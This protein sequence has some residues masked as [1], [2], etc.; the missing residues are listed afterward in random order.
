[1]THPCLFPTPVVHIFIPTRFLRIAAFAGILIVC[2]AVG[3]VGQTPVVSGPLIFLP[4]V[5]YSEGLNY[6]ILIPAA[7]ADVNGDGKLDIALISTST[8]VTVALGNGDGSFQGPQSYSPG[9]YPSGL[10][11]ADVNGDGK[12]DLVVTGC[13]PGGDP[14][15]PDAV[16]VML[17]NGDGSFKSGP[18][19][20]TG[21]LASVPAVADLNGDGKPDLVVLNVCSSLPCTSKGTLGVLLGKG[22]GTFEPVVTYNTGGFNSGALAIAD[23]NGDGNPDLIVGNG[24]N[25][26]GTCSTYDKNH[27]LGVLLGKGDGTFRPVVPY[28]SGGYE[29][30]S[31]TAIDLN[32]DGKLD[33]VAENWCGTT[34][35]TSNSSVGVLFGNGDGTFQA[36]TAYDVGGGQATGLAVLDGNGDGKPDFIITGFCDENTPGCGSTGAELFAILGN[37]NGTFQPGVI[38]Y[39]VGTY[40]GLKTLLSADLNGDGKP[41][42]VLIH[43]CNSLDC[44]LDDAEVGVMLNNLGAPATTVSVSSSKNPIPLL[45][46]VTYTATVAGGSGG[47][48]SGTVTFAD[49]DGPI[50]TATLSAGKASFMTSYKTAG[51]HAIT[52]TYSGVLHSDESSRSVAL[53]ENSV[54]PTTTVLA[55]SGSPTFVGK[56]VTFTA[57]VTSKY[58]TIPNGEPVSFYDGTTLLASV[59][60]SGGKAAYTT[61]ALTAKTHAMKAI[62]PGDSVFATSTGRVTQVVEPYATTTSLTSTPNPSSVGQTVTMTATVKSAGP[63]T[64]TGKVV[65]KDGTTWIGAAT[66]SGVVAKL[67]K[68]NLA[69]GTHSI[70]ATYDGDSASAASTSLAVNQVVQ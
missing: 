44:T 18:A 34:D 52:A 1:M 36:P 32:G 49:G 13:V 45:Q 21:G 35:C 9:L 59:A 70:T 16:T 25:S 62:Y 39:M 23:V 56:P 37:G 11:I 54:D 10:A 60:L 55:T 15:S 67:S 8:T 48:I 7:V 24:C 38:L 4:Q 27:Q 20:S 12:P 43:G 22:D 42:L 46:K 63:D 58:G 50:G 61:S 47:A 64:P 3:A 17:G 33:L 40:G 68:S 69:A 30:N 57:T 26:S 51:S 41:D 65:F 19:Y 31:I 28:P 5:N 6:S 53:T 66:L 29:V 14:C 2:F